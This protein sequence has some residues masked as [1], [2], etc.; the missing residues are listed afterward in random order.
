MKL[1][2][3]TGD[4]NTVP[5]H[6]K[7]IPIDFNRLL[8][9][10]HRPC[11]LPWKH[12]PKVLWNTCTIMSSE[13]S[14]TRLKSWFFALFSSGYTETKVGVHKMFTHNKWNPSSVY[15]LQI[16]WN[17][18]M[19]LY[20]VPFVSSDDGNGLLRSCWHKKEILSLSQP[21]LILRIPWESHW[22][23]IH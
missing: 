9:S 19:N 4:F 20:N 17:L 10:K 6:S 18:A 23:H 15:S 5:P 2:H 8:P 14:H 21:H 3:R 16:S 12:A 11:P 22:L 7:S 1:Y 13:G